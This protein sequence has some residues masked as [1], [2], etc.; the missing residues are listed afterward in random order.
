MTDTTDKTTT[1]TSSG[2]GDGVT[3]LPAFDLSKMS[4]E[5][6]LK[7]DLSTIGVAEDAANQSDQTSQ[8]NADAGTAGTV[9]TTVQAKGEGDP[10]VPA[11]G[12]AA[13]PAG[14]E[15]APQAGKEAETL[16][17]EGKKEGE[18]PATLT[19]EEQLAAIFAPMKANG[20]E[21]TVDNID[22]IRTL[23][24]KGLGYEK[25]RRDIKPQL[26]LV[27]LLER[28]GI[29]E[30]K[31]AHLI[32]VSKNN[33]DAITKAVKDSGVALEDIDLEKADY[34]PER[35][36]VSDS[37]IALDATFK[38]L[39]GKPGFSEALGVVA[40]VWDDASRVMVNEN[41]SILNML[42]NHVESGV[43]PLVTAEMQKERSL[44]R[45]TG[46]SDIDAYDVTGKAMDARGAF[47]K[48]TPATEQTQNK[49]AEPDKTSPTDANQEAIQ[50]KLNAQRKKAAGGQ[51]GTPIETTAGDFPDLSSLSDEDFMEAMRT[52]KVK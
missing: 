47:G 7:L 34:T 12:S 13:V 46:L 24:S 29:D 40:E 28:H 43:Y 41:P 4:D 32:Q 39:D 14:K 3:D 17:Q 35:D 15:D 6:V 30:S 1:A 23:I 18:L 44:G 49:E 33:P 48:Q 36:E 20:A 27:K 2:S 51:G 10:Q 16:K 11:G 45:L 42:T 37:D 5:E 31:L 8:P 9:D 26:K 50:A 38:E 21:V 22:D 19:A 25:N 52:G